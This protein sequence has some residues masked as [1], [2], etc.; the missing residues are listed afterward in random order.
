MCA[1]VDHVGRLLRH[2]LHGNKRGPHTQKEAPAPLAGNMSHQP[3]PASHAETVESSNTSCCSA[4]RSPCKETVD[5]NLPPP[6]PLSVFLSTSPPLF[7]TRGG[8]SAKSRLSRDMY[9]MCISTHCLVSV[10][11]LISMVVLPA[12]N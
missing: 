7:S 6:P 4:P 11:V 3:R 1:H 10:S 9:D 12:V 8:K 5:R 2:R